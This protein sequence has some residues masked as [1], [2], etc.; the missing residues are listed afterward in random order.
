M[1]TAA[2][3]RRWEILMTESFL[4]LNEHVEG[5]QLLLHV[6]NSVTDE[7]ANADNVMLTCSQIVLLTCY[8]GLQLKIVI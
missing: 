7:L 6:L 2:V 8:H 1:M 3:M 4:L 5:L